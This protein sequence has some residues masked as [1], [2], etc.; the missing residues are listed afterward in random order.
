MVPVS[1]WALLVSEADKI[2]SL[3]PAR[4]APDRVT[5]VDPLTRLRA[6]EPTTALLPT[7]PP[8]ATFQRFAPLLPETETFPAADADRSAL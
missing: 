2:T 7:M 3:N 8:P 1:V 5:P 6:T 4:L